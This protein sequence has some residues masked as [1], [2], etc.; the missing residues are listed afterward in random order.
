MHGCLRR[1]GALYASE[2]KACG[3]GIRTA[4]KSNL[5][6]WVTMGQK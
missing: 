5:S 4:L 1:V 6:G 2:I 3:N